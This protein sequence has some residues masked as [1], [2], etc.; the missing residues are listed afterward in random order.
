MS[1]YWQEIQSHMDDILTDKEKAQQL[2]QQEA[3][4]REE[5]VKKRDEEAR[6]QLYKEIATNLA[7]QRR[8]GS[9]VI[10]IFEEARTNH[11]GIRRARA[12]RVWTDNRNVLLEWGEKIGLTD[13]EATFVEKYRDIPGSA[14]RRFGVSVPERIVQFDGYRIEADISGINVY[15]IGEVHGSSSPLR[16]EEVIDNPRCLLPDL[17]RALSNPRH[18]VEVLQKGSD[19]WRA[20]TPSPDPDENNPARYGSAYS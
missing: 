18:R 5:A 2:A 9:V 8:A 1:R 7:R 19:Y 16:T 15:I 10:P 20:H 6:A 14:W 17:A 4:E 11:P 3:R 12:S 13:E